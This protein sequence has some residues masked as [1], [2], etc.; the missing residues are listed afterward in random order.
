MTKGDQQE[1][2][3]DISVI[4]PL[5]NAKG[6]LKPAVDSILNQTHK[7]IEVIIVDDCSTDGSL[8]LCRELYGNNERVVILKQPKNGG[9]GEAR[10]TGLCSARGKYIAFVDSDDEIL[11]D[12]LG[13]LF[14]TAESYNADVVHNTH[15]IFSVPDEN[16]VMPLEMIPSDPDDENTLIVPQPTDQHNL[17]LEVT[18]LSEDLALRFSNWLN[19]DYHWALWNKLFRRSFLEKHEI[20]FGRMKLGEDMIFCLECLMHAET[21]IVLPGGGYI[22]RSV[23]SISRG[24]KTPANTI[25]YLQA[26]LQIASY[27]P[28]RLGRMEFFRQHPEN[29]LKAIDLG[30][31]SLEIA[32]IRPAY[33]A[34]GEAAMREDKTVRAFFAENFG[35]RAPYVEFLFYQLHNAYPEVVDYVVSTSDAEIS[36]QIR[37]KVLEAKRA[38]KVI[39]D[40]SSL[41]AE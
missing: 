39:K 24:N 6:Y 22:Y 30:L 15:C 17:L 40:L 38:G 5:Y 12:T 21:Y 16:G 33:Q 18:R 4:M 36:R 10:N 7:N 34:L 35:E 27:L 14:E 32:F 1:M 29:I 25:K 11:P 20:S 23:P 2:N 37:A 8:D 3:P 19:H 41:F 26:Q 13:K 31:S 9:A 28:E